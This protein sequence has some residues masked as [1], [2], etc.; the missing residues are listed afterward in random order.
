MESENN[1]ST[2]KTFERGLKIFEYLIVHKKVSVTEL[3]K[4]LQMQKSAAYRFLNTLRIMGYAQQNEQ[5]KYIITN[6]LEKLISGISTDIDI[7]SLTKRHIDKLA[8]ASKQTA[9][10]GY[11]DGREIVYAAQ[12]ALSF[13]YYTEGNHIPA[14][15]SAMGKAIL[16]FLPEE[17]LEQY[18]QQ[19]ILVP[20]TQNTICCKKKLYEELYHIRN[21]GYAVTNSEMVT[22]LIGV[23]APIF[24][25]NNMPK[26][27]ISTAG[28]CNSAEEFI[29][30]SRDIVLSISCEI[31]LLLQKVLHDKEQSF[32]LNNE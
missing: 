14:Y 20:F 25:N 12:K 32:L 3:A 23:A 8:Y 9:N 13:T 6:R 4:T 19:T 26:Y 28:I 24:D 29:Q 17:E 27:A 10:I 7:K 18:L 11:F 21:V 5:N 22:N 1:F 16:A 15:C 2:A 30:L 31:S